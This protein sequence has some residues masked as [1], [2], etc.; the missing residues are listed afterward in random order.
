MRSLSATLMC[1]EASAAMR[2]GRLRVE[3]EGSRAREKERAKASLRAKAE[4]PFFVVKRLFGLRKAVYKGL[5]K[6]L[7]RLRL[8]FL[9]SNL[10]MASWRLERA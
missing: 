9:S 7:D 8:L 2:P 4:H 1:E 5:A 3:P 10:L 6:N